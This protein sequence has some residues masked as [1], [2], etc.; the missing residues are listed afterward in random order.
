MSQELSIALTEIP[1]QTL[2][3]E[4]KQVMDDK[5]IV[6]VFDNEKNAYEG[7]KALSDLHAEGSITL[8]AS[9][10]I[11]KDA[12]GRVNVKQIADQGPIGTGLG[13]VTGTLIGLLGGPAGVAVGAGVGTFGGML[14]DFAKVGVGEDFLEE[15]AQQMKPGKV[16][17]VAEVQEEWVMPLDTRMEA[18]GGVVIRRMR[19]EVLDS[20][21]ERDAAALKAEIADLKA[22]HALARQESKA[23]L[24][25]KINAVKAR[26][27]ETRDRAKAAAE[28]TEKEMEAK[29]KALKEQAAKARGDAKTKLEARIAEVQA[30]Y[31]RRAM[32]LHEAWEIAKEALS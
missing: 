32:K 19:G 9:A 6:A 8:Y 21:I 5:M 27:Q 30:D 7:T 14:H 10:V 4:R 29:V 31:K 15:V 18:V 16:A 3:T 12:G 11:A 20:Q 17:V 28:A 13:L 24:E 2:L 26:L 1:Q 22:E 25:A 23:K